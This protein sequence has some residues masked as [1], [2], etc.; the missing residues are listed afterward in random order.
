[1]PVNLF[2]L[3]GRV[4]LITGGNKG[5][6]KAMAR[7][8]AEAGADVV[9]ASRHEDQLKAALDEILAGTGRKGIYVVADVSKRNDV[10]NLARTAVDRM[11][12]V[13]IL[14]N[15]AG[16]NAPQ[17]IDEVSDETWDRVVE[18][19]LTSVMALTRE[20]VPQMKAR[21]W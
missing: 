19:N 7:G 14:V 13:D 6:G 20:L 9:I 5:L 16:M 10:K 11:G 12:R 2:D 15:N 8:F 17:A 1:M 21:K 18:V 4:A 3:T